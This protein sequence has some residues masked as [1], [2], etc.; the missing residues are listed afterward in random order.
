MFS[1]V[2]MLFHTEKMLKWTRHAQHT[3]YHPL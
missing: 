2:E 1:L 3:W